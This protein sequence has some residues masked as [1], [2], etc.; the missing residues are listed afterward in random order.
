[1]NGKAAYVL[2]LIVSILA[3]FLV[4]SWAGESRYVPRSEFEIVCKQLDNID[5][6]IDWLMQHI[7]KGD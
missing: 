3:T 7:P 2:G 6:K 4:A 5:R 1:M